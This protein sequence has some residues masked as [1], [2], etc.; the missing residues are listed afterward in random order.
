MMDER[1]PI[2]IGAGQYRQKD[3]DPAQAREPLAMM[4][5]C[6]RE[7]T[8]D[9]G[10][11]RR[12]LGQLD[13]VAV[14]NIFG[15]HYG[16][17]PRA[18]A[19]QLGAQPS[20]EIY[21]TLGGNTPQ[22]LVN[23]IAARIAAGKTRLALL[24]GVE[25]VYSV[26][27]ARRAGVQ[28]QWSSGASGEPT[29]IGE[30]RPGTTDHEVAHGAMLPTTIY[31]MFE[32]ALRAHYGLSIAQHRQRLGQLCSRFTEVAAVNRY[33]WFPVR[34]SAEEIV[35]VTPQNRMIGF[36]YPKYMNAILDVDQAAA[37]IMTSVGHARALGID[38][39][40]WVYLWGCGDA[41]DLWFVSERVNYFSSPAIRLAGHKALAMAGVGIER[42]DHFDLYSC[43]PSAVQIGRDMLGI[44]AD[45]PRP[46]TVTGG[47]PYHGGPGNN[48]VMHSIATMMA[49]LRA[50][51]GSKGLVTGLGWYVT[52]HSVGIYST[53]PPARSFV[54]EDPKQYQSQIDAEPHPALA[55]EP[56]GRG[57]IET[58]TVAHDRDGNPV[59]GIVIGRLEDGR[60]FL[61]NT[62]DDRETLESLM[63]NEGVGRRG[64]VSSANGA[65]R[66]EL[67]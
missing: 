31:P 1:R 42:I 38:P 23:E 30:D 41:H 33:A 49:K 53:E 66:F 39:S 6:A 48:Y 5:E 10:S 25:A 2:L 32:N 27:R 64:V 50:Q 63:I 59:R 17:P 9:A 22:Y 16:N 26:A 43:F 44:P 8:A 19:E 36:P 61:A 24:A 65:N 47:L 54:R 51:P 67:Q 52:K 57:A 40:R 35:T 3:V 55:L 60:R 46:L 14:V 15:W 29:V 4:A 37:V 45:D 18:L 58:Y 62:P 11:D 20:S 21:T 13:C 56:H 7:A 34:R 12:L 28:L